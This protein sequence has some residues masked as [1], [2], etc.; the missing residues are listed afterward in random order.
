VTSHEVKEALLL[1]R[2]GVDDETDPDFAPALAQM[3]N[4]PELKKWFDQHC[5]MQKAVFAGFER[6]HVP[7]GLKEQILSERPQQTAPGRRPKTLTL[8]LAAIPLFLLLALG[9]AYLR[10]PSGPD[11]PTYRQAMVAKANPDRYPKMDLY[12]DDLGQIRKYLAEHGGQKDYVLPAGLEK[13]AGTGCKIFDWRGKRV[14]MVCL[15]SGKNGTPKTPD[16]FLFIV[17][18]SGVQEPSAHCAGPG[19]AMADVKTLATAG[20][21]NGDKTYLLAGSGD[22][23]FLKRFY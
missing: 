21:T 4:D 6:L 3:R 1:F 17:D 15:N 8:V 19:P 23:E 16:L 18:R 9:I 2:P 20:W 5:A 11:F 14:S 13:L 22:Q 12:T 7:E 10:S